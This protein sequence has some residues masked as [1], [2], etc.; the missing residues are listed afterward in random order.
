MDG[1]SCGTDPEAHKLRKEFE[2]TGGYDHAFAMPS[3]LHI[4]TNEKARKLGLGY[5]ECQEIVVHDPSQFKDNLCINEE[6]KFYIKDNLYLSKD[7]FDYDSINAFY[8]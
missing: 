4:F 8:A 1:P 6:L 7:K 3:L 5:E 2:V